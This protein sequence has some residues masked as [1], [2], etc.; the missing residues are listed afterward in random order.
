M[1]ALRT[2][3]QPFGYPPAHASRLESERAL[4][5]AMLIAFLVVGGALVLL[6]ALGLVHVERELRP[7]GE[8]PVIRLV[9]PPGA[10]PPACPASRPRSR[11]RSTWSA[12]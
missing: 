2:S 6:P 7:Q 5:R 12:S 1:T 10:V 11:S 4:T 8:G 9:R 3:L